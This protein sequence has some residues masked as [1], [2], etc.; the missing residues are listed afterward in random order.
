[1]P[2]LHAPR[3]ERTAAARSSGRL[4]NAPKIASSSAPACSASANR[5]SQENRRANR[6]IRRN[7]S[8]RTARKT[9]PA[10]SAARIPA[11]IAAAAAHPP[12]RRRGRQ[13]TIPAATKMTCEKNCV[14]TSRTT[15]AIA[16]VA[17][18]NR[19]SS[20]IRT[21]SPPIAADGVT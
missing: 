11:G 9:R 5:R 14:I 19:R 8:D 13:Y 15:D 2:T 3:K 10:A 1:M 16:G 7:P 4:R 6:S 12:A 20:A 21:S 17:A 18:T